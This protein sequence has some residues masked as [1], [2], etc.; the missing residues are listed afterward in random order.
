MQ[1]QI[2]VAVLVINKKDE[3]LLIKEKLSDVKQAK[4]NTIK[5]TYESTKETIFEAAVREC[6]EEASARVELTHALGVYLY[7]GKAPRIQFNFLAVAK[8]DKV[9]VP[10]KYQQKLRN[11]DISEVRWF[12]RE[13]LTKLKE[14]DYVSKIAYRIVQGWLK[15]DAKYPLET[16]KQFQS[17]LK[18]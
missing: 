1:A 8:N 11:E 15:D 4:W 13:D 10:N 18:V 16:Y 12:E 7:G 6:F 9:A 14:A 2:K 3:L 5:G 17:I